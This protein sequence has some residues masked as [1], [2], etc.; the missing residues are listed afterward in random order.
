M[1]KI[2]CSTSNQEEFAVSENSNC[3]VCHATFEEVSQLKE[4]MMKHKQMKRKTRA[5]NYELNEK[6]A[7]MKLLKG[8]KREKHLD[9]EI[10][11]TCVNV[12]FSD[13]SYHEVLLPFLREW[14][15]QVDKPFRMMDLDI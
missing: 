7:K 6:K 5:F 12:R 3:T 1:M 14:H 4:H 9:V 10:K 8:A 13:G 2:E 15:K 11:S